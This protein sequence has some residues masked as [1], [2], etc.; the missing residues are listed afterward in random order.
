MLT[1][2]SRFWESDSLSFDPWK[3]TRPKLLGILMA[4]FNE[5]QVIS[6]LGL[7]AGTMLDF[8][9]S[10]EKLYKDVPY[11]SFY[12]AVDVVVKLF[13]VLHD[14]NM[15]AYFTNYDVASLLI[16]GLC[17]DAGHPG[18]NNLYQAN[19]NTELS[20]K[21]PDAILER[22]SIDLAR[23]NI[24][25]HRMF[26]NVENKFNAGYLDS[27]TTAMTIGERMRSQ[28]S[29]AILY[30]DMSRH[31]QVV[32][33][34][35]NLINFL[36]KKAE[37]LLENKPPYHAEGQSEH[38]PDKVTASPENLSRNPSRQSLEMASTGYQQSRATKKSSSTQ[39]SSSGHNRKPSMLSNKRIRSLSLPMYSDE[40]ILNS[41]QRQSLVNI[42][43]H[44]ID[45]FNPVLPWN[46]CKR[47][48]DLM[49]TESFRQGD[50]EKSQGLPVTPS[51]DRDTSDQCTI[52]INFGTMIIKPFFEELVCLFPVE[53]PIL[54][55]LDNNLEVWHE[56]RLEKSKSSPIMSQP[57]PITASEL[58]PY[59]FPSTGQEDR[60]LSVAAGTIELPTIVAESTRRHSSDGFFSL[61][62]YRVGP[63]LSRHLERFQPRRRIF[64]DYGNFHDEQQQNYLHSRSSN[65][66]NG[67]LSSDDSFSCDGGSD[68]NKQH[69]AC[70]DAA[71]KFGSGSTSNPNT[72]PPAPEDAT[73]ACLRRE[74]RSTSLDPTLFSTLPPN[75]RFSYQMG[76][77][78]AGGYSL[79]NPQSR[80]HNPSGYGFRSNLEPPCEE[81]SPH[82]SDGGNSSSGGSGNNNGV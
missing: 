61:Q 30:T 52:S 25:K 48:S 13:Y 26:C 8:I 72:T 36:S 69:K 22:Y 58:Y 5:C 32:E 14:L 55:T 57:S 59:P 66:E 54:E 33:Q 40:L 9:L 4:V 20:K 21:Y 43:L 37:S 29:E 64:G 46:M 28:I 35:T 41:V 11:H 12:H 10:I 51:T 39:S 2:V 53:E 63:V 60:R 75:Y 67:E 77:L 1:Y 56:M 73:Q 6:V 78:N 24:E 82:H 42:L 15:D 65:C 19:A 76:G 27:T 38:T 62:R 49:I 44:S 7:E 70:K 31:F 3:Y 79:H 34:C 18:L 45:V 81:P 80:L 68:R 47:W 17:H 23:E 74:R 50:L 16:A 71:V